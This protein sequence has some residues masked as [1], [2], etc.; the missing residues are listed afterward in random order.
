M[1]IVIIVIIVTICIIYCH[2][3]HY[4][5]S[6]SALFIVIEIVKFEGN[7]NP[8]ES[9]SAYVIRWINE[10]LQ[11]TYFLKSFSIQYISYISGCITKSTHRV[12][13]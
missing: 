2:Y 9:N 13:L 5:L 10:S 3:L 4:L 1:F 11:K 12:T 6:L 8:C 7:A